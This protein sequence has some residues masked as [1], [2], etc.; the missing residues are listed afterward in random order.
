[1]IECRNLKFGHGSPKSK[2]YVELIHDISLK[3]EDGEFVAIIGENGA[4][5]STLSKIL[6]G[7]LKPVE[8]TVTVNGMDTKKTKNS[9]L[10]K[11]LGF[12]FQNPDRQL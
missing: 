2:T 10:A 3:I 7:L 9:V 12:L 6:A 5:K 1:M 8:G 11:Q 4:G